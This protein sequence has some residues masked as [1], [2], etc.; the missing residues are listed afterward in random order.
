[1]LLNK[2]LRPQI[3]EVLWIPDIPACFKKTRTL[4][5][6]APVCQRGLFEAE[7]DRQFFRAHKLVARVFHVSSVDCRICLREVVS[8]GKINP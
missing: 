3:D 5:L 6:R 2:R 8:E 7:V 4:F 1:M